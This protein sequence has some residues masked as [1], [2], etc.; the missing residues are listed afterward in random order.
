MMFGCMACESRAPFFLLLIA[1]RGTVFFQ[2]IL[3]FFP[4]TKV[5]LFRGICK[6]FMLIDVNR[7]K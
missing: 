6:Y 7:I 1:K 2:R 4:T 3:C 5:Q